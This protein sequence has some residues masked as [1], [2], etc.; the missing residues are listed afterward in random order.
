MYLVVLVLKGKLDEGGKSWGMQLGSP[1]DLTLPQAYP[2]VF[3]ESF[4]F[5]GLSFLLSKMSGL[6]KIFSEDL[7][8]PTFI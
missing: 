5:P 3:S 2:V 8:L 7:P 6:C 1:C 4:N